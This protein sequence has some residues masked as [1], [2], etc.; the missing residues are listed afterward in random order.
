MKKI[1]TLLFAVLAFVGC[2]KFD[3]NNLDRYVKKG[4]KSVEVQKAIEILSKD[5]GFWY[6]SG[7]KSYVKVLNEDGTSEMVPSSEIDVRYG[8]SSFYRFQFD[9]NGKVAAYHFTDYPKHKWT[10]Y[11]AEID[12]DKKTISVDGHCEYF[13]KGVTE[14]YLIIEE[15]SANYFNPKYIFT[16]VYVRMSDVDITRFL[17]QTDFEDKRE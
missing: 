12:W 3:D 5:R 7:K 1:L 15:N 16:D 4:A 13:L 8:V 6:A 11:D 2:D 9:E 17:T 14:N 10:I